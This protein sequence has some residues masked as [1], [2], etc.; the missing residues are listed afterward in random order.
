MNQWNAVVLGGGDPG[1]ALAVAHGVAVKPLI[2][3][4][5]RPMGQ[6]VLE[7][8]RGS[9]SVNHVAYVGPLTPSMRGLVDLEVPDAGRLIANLE[10]GLRALGEQ[11]RVLVATA[12]VP[13]ISGAMLRDVLDAA[14][15]AGL[16][17]P[18][19]RREVCEAAF[20]G[21][22]RT[23]VKLKEGRFTG[24]NVFLLDPA[25][26]LRFLPK[27]EQLLAQRKRPL[28]LAGLIGWPVLVR[29]LTGRLSLSELERRVSAILGAPVRA[30]ISEHAAIG[31]DVDKEAD[32]DLVRARLKQ[33]PS[34]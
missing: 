18:I 9:G 28:A 16:V 25:L 11:R 22:K 33:A 32:L 1:E 29:L 20:P 24:G 27:I 15:E 26:A 5:G 7:A 21:V 12:D 3:L 17:Y 10:A 19:V 13:L 31:T 8:L 34:S 14:P 30:L 6:Y 2:E 4:D 23:Y